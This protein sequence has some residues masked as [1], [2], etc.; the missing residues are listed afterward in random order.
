M[1]IRVVGQVVFPHFVAERGEGV[2]EAAAGVMKMDT[3]QPARH[4][5]VPPENLDR[6]IFWLDEGARGQPRAIVRAHH[7]EASEIARRHQAPLEGHAVLYLVR[8]GCK[9]WVEC[10]V[11]Q[12]PV[13]LALDAGTLEE[14]LI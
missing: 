2:F 12:E 3:A 10:R 4:D 14:D 13:D 1:V 11:V 9:S 8:V 5:E 6:I 7:G